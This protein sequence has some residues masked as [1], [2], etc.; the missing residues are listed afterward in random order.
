MS[1]MH[2]FCAAV[3]NNETSDPVIMHIYKKKSASILNLLIINLF[4]V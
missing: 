1:W 2:E 3:R 4:I